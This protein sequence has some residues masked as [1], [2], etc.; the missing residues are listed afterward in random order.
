VNA[1]AI[2][3]GAR[4]GSSF[5]P[6]S[7]SVA[8]RVVAVPS[9]IQQFQ[10]QPLY[11]SAHVPMTRMRQTAVAY[12]TQQQRKSSVH[13]GVPTRTPT[14]TPIAQQPLSSVVKASF[15]GGKMAANQYLA[16]SCGLVYH[17]LLIKTV[18]SWLQ[19]IC[20]S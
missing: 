12:G 1:V 3:D 16:S 19:T 14:V 15:T 20:P 4:F 18:L 2:D 8:H 6:D 5:A 7:V 10:Q 17:G 11:G 13:V 9:G